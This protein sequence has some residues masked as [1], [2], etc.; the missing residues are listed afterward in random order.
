MDDGAEH[1][2]FR[3]ARVSR[4]WIIGNSGAARECFW[5][6]KDMLAADARLEQECRFGGFLSWGGYPSNLKELD[7]WFRG[8]VEAYAI[9][10][11]DVFAIGVGAP[12]LRAAIYAAMKER[13]ADFF[14]LMHP[15]AD[16]NPSARI[17]EANI[18][19]RSCSVFC[20]ASIGHANYLNGAVNLAHDVVAG[21]ANFFGPFS[22]VLGNCRVGSRNQLAV[23]VALLPGSRI[24]DDNIIA[25]GSVVYKGCGHG[26][27]MAGNPALP[28]G[29]V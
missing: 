9:E 22:L 23:H 5:I 6:F 4:L 27:R 11:E 20:D 17:G 2:A 16:V 3:G 29:E 21:A 19:Q 10:P 28:M 14:T 7:S 8:P 24:G 15:L 25:P 18:F 13:G 26:R 1:S 12:R